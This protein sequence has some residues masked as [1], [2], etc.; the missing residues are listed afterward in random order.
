MDSRRTSS[1]SRPVTNHLHPRRFRNPR[2][3]PGFSPDGPSPR[4]TPAT[5]DRSH[6]SQ[7]GEEEGG[8]PVS[9]VTYPTRTECLE[10]ILRAFA[11]IVDRDDIHQAAERLEFVQQ[12]IKSEA[13]RT[14][15]D[16]IF[17]DLR[18]V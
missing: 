6:S 4:V 1:A 8:L 12:W 18:L 11:D 17:A 9:S 13:E 16:P 15:A 3:T 5:G 10:Q 2:L 7:A 14:A